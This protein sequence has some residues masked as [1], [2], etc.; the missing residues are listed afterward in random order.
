M[1]EL[2]SVC[3]HVCEYMCICVCVCVYMHPNEHN[4][5]V[6]STH[7]DVKGYRAVFTG[8]FNFSHCL[9]FSIIRIYFKCYKNETK[10]SKGQVVYVFTI[11]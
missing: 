1:Y 9:K 8:F 11:N 10:K 7:L 5:N 6:N 4:Q 3:V 2:L